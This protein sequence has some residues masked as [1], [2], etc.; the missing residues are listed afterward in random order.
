M[1]KKE[2]AELFDRIGDAM[3]GID[4]R[5]KVEEA[6]AAEGRERSEEAVETTVDQLE[7]MAL[8]Y[9]TAMVDACDIA[10]GDD[11]VGDVG[12][13]ALR[14]IDTM[15]ATLGPYLLDRALDSL[16]RLIDT[17]LGGLR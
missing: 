13:Y 17:E 9:V 5:A 11:E 16:A 1:K 8:G 4:I 14:A 10:R 6:V 2:L 3:G 15:A 12:E 7:L